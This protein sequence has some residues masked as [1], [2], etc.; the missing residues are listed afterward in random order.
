MET[1]D[2]MVT[3]DNKRDSYMTQQDKKEERN[4]SRPHTDARQYRIR[5]NDHKR[6]SIGNFMSYM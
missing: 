4:S 2:L 6:S 3:F 5:K 1:D